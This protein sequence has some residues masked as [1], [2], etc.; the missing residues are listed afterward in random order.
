MVSA[1]LDL[2]HGGFGFGRGH[3]TR[4]HEKK[5]DCRARNHTPA[6]EG[7]PDFSTRR[8]ISDRMHFFS[9]SGFTANSLE[10]YQVFQVHAIIG[11]LIGGAFQYKGFP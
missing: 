3:S 2:I 11:F 8:P 1:K 9:L 6:R 7:V 5:Q 4:G 10:P